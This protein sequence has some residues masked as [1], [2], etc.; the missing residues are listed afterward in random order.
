M[1]AGSFMYIGPQGIVHGTTITVLNAG[2][3]IAPGK[4]GLAG[5]VFVSAGLGGMSGAQAKAAVIAGAIAVIAEINPLA[6]TKRHTQG[7]VDEVFTDL[8]SLMARINQARSKKDERPPARS[9][10][11]KRNKIGI[12]LGK[13]LCVLYGS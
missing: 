8:N 13:A 9:Q 12:C 2:R 1:T 5:K 6:V 3:K 4:E 10:N 11:S 7:W